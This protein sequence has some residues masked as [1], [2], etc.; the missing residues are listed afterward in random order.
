MIAAALTGIVLLTANTASAGTIGGGNF[1]ISCNTSYGYTSDNDFYS[2][3][4]GESFKVHNRIVAMAVSVKPVSKNG[5]M[6]AAYNI[7][8]SGYKS[9]ILPA[10]S[11]KLQARAAVNTNCNSILP[12]HGTTTWYYNVSYGY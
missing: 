8:G 9:W 5:Y 10:G 4:S 3:N 2:I 7:P 12:G 6:Y 11:Y 1:E